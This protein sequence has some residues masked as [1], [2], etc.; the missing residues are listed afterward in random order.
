MGGD[1]YWKGAFVDITI[2]DAEVVAVHGTHPPMLRF[3][4]PTHSQEMWSLPLDHVQIQVS[5]PR[6]MHWPPQCADV[7]G[8][9]H[10]QLWFAQDLG[11]SDV[12]PPVMWMVPARPSE[13]QP[14]PDT[15]DRAMQAARFLAYH[16]PVRLLRRQ[17]G[18]LRR[19]SGGA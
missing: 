8:D 19:Q 12:D 2:R 6:P 1:E 5:Q 16:G 13:V 9:H 7:W 15:G 11:T 4:V 17:S 14:D 10:G 3:T 18:L